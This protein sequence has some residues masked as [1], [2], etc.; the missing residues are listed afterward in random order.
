MRLTEIDINNIT[1]DMIKQI[2]FNVP[3]ESYSEADCIVVFGCHLKEMTDERINCALEILKIK[4][5]D[6]ILLTG[7]IGVLGDF[8]E[9]EYMKNLLLEN[10][11]DESRILVENKSTTTE[12]NI[13]NSIEILKANELVDN[14]NLVLLSNEYHL[15]R[16][17][18]EFKKQLK[19]IE[20]KFIYEYPKDSLLSY[21]KVLNDEK[22]LEFIID[23]IKRIINYINQGIMDDENI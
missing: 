17:G 8:N 23:E 15:R 20:C 16:I 2:L 5:I 6:K 4:K 10:G 9:S 19:D 18:M 14:K 3:D 12:E 21:K 7:G 11:I 22:L 1:N 13:I